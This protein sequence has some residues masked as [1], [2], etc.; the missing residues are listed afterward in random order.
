MIDRTMAAASALSA[1]EAVAAGRKMGLS[2]ASLVDVFGKGS[3]RNYTTRFVLPAL[4]ERRNG[5]DANLGA[6]SR[7]VGEI[8]S[9]GIACGIPTPM[10][11]AARALLQAAR[12]TLGAQAAFQDIGQMVGTM[13]GT[14]LPDAGAAT[15]SSPA[16]GASAAGGAVTIGYVGLGAMGAPLARR[17]MLSYKVHAY[18]VRPDAARAL[19]AEGAIPETELATLARKCDVIVLCVPSSAIVREVL[20]GKGGLAEGLSPG[21]IVIDQTTGDPDEAVAIAAE[22]DKLGVPLIDAPVSGG[23]ETP[24]AGT[25][26]MICGGPADAFGRIMPVLKAIGPTVIYCGPVGSGHAAKLVNNAS[27]ICNRLIAYEAAMIAVKNGLALDV[28]H[29]VVNKSVGW[30]FAAERVF[31]AVASHARTASISL[32]LS[33]K[34][35]ASAVKMGLDAGAPMLMADTARNIFAMGVHQFG[36]DANVDEMAHL[37]EKM[38][39]IDFTKV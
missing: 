34:D 5:F 15:A 31:K 22:L 29:Q 17:L 14:S 2:L 39:G 18:D 24:L 21:K 25:A 38:A 13:A 27:N 9:L 7:D 30:S 12:N 6:M 32:E 19:E 35:V 11:T 37:Y 10:A 3:G 36:G 16:P 1:L 8:V 33:L 28:F 23:P 4:N 26:V 20:F